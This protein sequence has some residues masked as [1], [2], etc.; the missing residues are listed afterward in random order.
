MYDRRDHEECGYRVK[1]GRGQI[2][3]GRLYGQII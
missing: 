2:R 3:L 1:A